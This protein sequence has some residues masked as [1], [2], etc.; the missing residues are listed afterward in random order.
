M[1]TLVIAAAVFV[2]YKLI[3]ARRDP[4]RESG[5]S[6]APSGGARVVSGK[7]GGPGTTRPG[8]TTVGAKPPAKPD[9]SQFEWTPEQA[10]HEM[11]LADSAAGRTRVA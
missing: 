4:L 9:S 10:E 11:D 5:G 6:A 2:G 1:Q 8:A 3:S 7:P